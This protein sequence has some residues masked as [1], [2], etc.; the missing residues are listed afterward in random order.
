MVSRFERCVAAHAKAGDIDKATAQQVLD[1][2]RARIEQ[3]TQPVQASLDAAAAGIARAQEGL[4][5]TAFDILKLDA[6][7]TNSAGHARGRTA[8]VRAVF[9]W[10]PWGTS[11]Y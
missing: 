11:G 1:D 4:D 7:L 8:G 2:Y 10:D 3:G 9:S 5:R 6:A